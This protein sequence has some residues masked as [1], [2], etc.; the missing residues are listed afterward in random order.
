MHF[1][2][3]DEMCQ[4]LNKM[5]ALFTTLLRELFI[6]DKCNQIIINQLVLE[7]AKVFYFELIIFRSKCGKP[8]EVKALICDAAELKV[9]A[10]F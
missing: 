1:L 6:N 10:P 8:W 2:S 7:V 4:F 3:S 5:P 9:M